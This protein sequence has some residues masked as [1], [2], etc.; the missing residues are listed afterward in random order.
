MSSM[1]KTPIQTIYHFN[2]MQF[3]V[4]HDQIEKAIAIVQDFIFKNE[5]NPS[6]QNDLKLLKLLEARE[7][8]PRFE[9]DLAEMISG[10][11]GNSFPYRSSYYLTQFFKNLGLN[12]EHDGST[13]RFWVEEQLKR[14]NISMIAKVIRQGLFNRRDFRTYSNKENI[15]FNKTY[16]TAIIEFKSFIDDCVGDNKELD[17]SFLLNMNVNT[18]LLFNQKTVTRDKEL[19][20]LIN[21]SKSR[22]LNPNDK[23]IAL[24]KI[25][26]AFERI[27]TYY[28][29]NKKLSAQTLTS[30]IATDISEDILEKEFL[31]LTKI[32]NEYRIRHHE[33]GKVELKD[34]SQIEYLY[35]RVLTLID[36]CIRKIN[37]HGD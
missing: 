32:G 15:D 34:T 21:E 22:F 26:H 18:D 33:K 28:G 14:L 37:E 20:S 7:H 27:K 23:Q 19:N 16:A 24:E 12:F 4:K 8:N 35:F 1:M 25:W 29:P 30:K 6:D 36:L 5:L 9:K 31:S 3:E 10:E 11:E 17:L 13:R 2:K